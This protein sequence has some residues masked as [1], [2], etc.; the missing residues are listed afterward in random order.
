MPG[1]ALMGNTIRRLRRER[2]VGQAELARR[3]GISPS[4]LNLIE[5]NR[6]PLTGPLRVA[7]ATAMGLD[8]HELSGGEEARV[9]AGLAEAFGDPLFRDEGPGGQDIAALAVLPR[10]VSRAVLELHRAY[11][12]SREESRALGE[13][14]AD[15]TLLNAPAMELRG[16]VASIRSFGEILHD[17]ADLDAEERRRFLASLVRDSELLT[18]LLDRLP[19]AAHEPAADDAASGPPPT[20]G[21]PGPGEAA[22]FI[23]GR[24]NYFPALEEAAESLRGEALGGDSGQP[25]PPLLEALCRLLARRMGVAVQIVPGEAAPGSLHHY[26]PRGRRLLLSDSLPRHDRAFLVA[27]RLGISSAGRVL[28]RCL[29]EPPPPAP[30]LHEVCREALA[31]YFAGAVLMPYGAFRVAAQ[32]L[33]YDIERLRRLFGVGFEQACHRLTTLRRPGASGVPFHLVR[34]D[35]AGNVTHRFNGSGLRIARYGGVCPRWNVH[36]AFL[37]PG[38][39]QVQHAETPDGGAWLCIARTVDGPATGHHAPR[40]LASIAIGCDAAYAGQIVY[41]DGLDLSDRRRAEPVGVNCRLCGREDC[42]QRAF[43]P[44][45]IAM[46]DSIPLARH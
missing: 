39:V 30:V 36:G 4:Y 3:A 27:R 25:D 21:A 2:G 46:P 16:L 31:S 13:R 43:Q 44:L 15:E 17:H 29:E 26:H 33:R 35:I 34:V 42:R 12:A 24:N 22:E 19:G 41:A 5:H 40:S 20:L 8:A 37:S 10:D 38:R 18:E 45:D 14:L 6:R 32:K 23:E 7:L 11:R 1:R 28:E 9:L